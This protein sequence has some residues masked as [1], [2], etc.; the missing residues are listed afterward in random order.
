LTVATAGIAAPAL[1]AAAAGGTSAIVGWTAASV[2]AIASLAPLGAN[3]VLGASSLTLVAIKEEMGKESTKSGYNPIKPGES[4]RWRTDT[5]GLWRQGHCRCANI[6]DL[7]DE[8]KIV[9]EEAFL[10]PIFSGDTVDSNL[11]HTISFWIN[12]FGLEN[13][14]ETVL[15]LPD[16]F[17]SWDEVDAAAKGQN[18]KDVCKFD[19]DQATSSLNDEKEVTMAMTTEA[20]DRSAVVADEDPIYVC[21]MCGDGGKITNKAAIIKIPGYPKMSCG[22]LAE[23][24]KCGGISSTICPYVIHF[25][26]PCGCPQ[27]KSVISNATDTKEGTKVT[28]PLCKSNGSDGSKGV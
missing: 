16:G 4:Y 14:Q 28:R 13:N 1:T 20:T 22:D 3:V 25:I 8:K 24:A 19:E 2:G 7:G 23:Q 26:E 12:K 15:S 9:T 17:N 10:R 18:P 6:V 5:V 27:S 11:D 21:D